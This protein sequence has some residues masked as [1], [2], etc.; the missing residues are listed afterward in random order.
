M[1]MA[2]LEQD[3]YVDDIVRDKNHDVVDIVFDLI[4]TEL[5]HVSEYQENVL[6]A[7]EIVE[8]RITGLH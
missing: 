3:F 5:I 4:G 1:I 2:A 6:L 7:Q 8:A